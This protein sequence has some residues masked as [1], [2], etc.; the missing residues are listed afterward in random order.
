[1]TFVLAK[2][3]EFTWP[4]TVTLP[5]EKGKH[6]TRTFTGHF[7]MMEQGEFKE[8]NDA[9]QRA[10]AEDISQAQD[11]TTEIVVRTM[12]GW[13][14]VVDEDNQP[15]A[16]SEDTLRAACRF[17]PICRAIYEAYK[18]AVNP[19]GVKARRKGN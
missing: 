16:F 1:M 12:T 3:Y 5:D 10:L 14:E 4:V 7:R 11:T 17:G 15:I 18:D 6:V 8:M 2:Q 9:L 19:D 13:D